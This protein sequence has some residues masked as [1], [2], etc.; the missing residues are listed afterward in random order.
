MRGLAEL[1]GLEQGIVHM[2]GLNAARTEAALE[3]IA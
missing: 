2:L 3:M 1:R